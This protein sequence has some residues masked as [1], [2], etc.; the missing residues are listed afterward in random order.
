MGKRPL[1]I[2]HKPICMYY[3]LGNKRNQKFMFSLYSLEVSL[4]DFDQGLLSWDE[5]QKS[6]SD[7]SQFSCPKHITY[8]VGKSQNL[9][10]ISSSLFL[11]LFLWQVDFICS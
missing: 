2:I 5:S 6:I 8:L 9:D 1:Y 3:D 10:R 4:I 7:L 11:T